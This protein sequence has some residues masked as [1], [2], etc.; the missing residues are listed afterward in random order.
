M[1]AMEAIV[2]S[3]SLQQPT[4]AAIDVLGRRMYTAKTEEGI[5]PKDKSRGGRPDK[6]EKKRVVVRPPVAAPE[7]AAESVVKPNLAVRSVASSAMAPVAAS[8][9]A[10]APVARASGRGGTIRDEDYRYIYSDLRRIG[11]LAGSIVV[12]LVALS[13]ILR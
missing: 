8:R 4:Q 3:L 9:S 10:W 11:I 7:G 2:L 12:V 5:L 1:E 6:R 13:F